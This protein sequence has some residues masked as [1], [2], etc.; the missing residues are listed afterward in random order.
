[1]DTVNVNL[2]VPK[3]SKEV[4]DAVHA[5]LDHFVQGKSLAEA[6]LLLPSVMVAV[7]GMNKLGDEMKS[8]QVGG[9]AGYLVDRVMA[10]LLASKP[11]IVPVADA[12][13]EEGV[14]V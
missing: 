8:K 9:S 2:V 11:V 3:E 13:A 1:M 6:A 5:I 14:P 4:V 10:A 7:D 12:P